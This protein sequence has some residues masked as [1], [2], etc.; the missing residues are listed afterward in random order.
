MSLEVTTF[1]GYFKSEN[2]QYFQIKTNEL[3]DELLSKM[4]E[5]KQAINII[6]CVD[7]SGSMSLDNKLENVKDTLNFL[8]D[9]LRD[10]DQI[11]LVL[12][13]DN[14]E[15]IQTQFMTKANKENLKTI[16]KSIYTRGSTNISSACLKAIEMLSEDSVLNDKIILFLTDGIPNQ[17]IIHSIEMISTLTPK[18]LQQN[19]SL[20][21]FG[22]GSDHDHNLLGKLA[23]T[24]NG[25]YSYIKSNEDVMIS[26][27]NCLGGIFT[28]AIK[29]IEFTFKI[30]D[31]IKFSV[32]APERRQVKINDNETLLIMGNMT[33]GET[34]D[35]LVSFKTDDT[36]YLGECIIKYH[37]E[38]D[39]KDYEENL[40]LIITKDNNI[41]L[42]S[43]DKQF[44]FYDTY[45]R[46]ELIETINI[47]ESI[48]NISSIKE[49][50]VDKLGNDFIEKINNIKEIFADNA[51]YLEILDGYITTIKNI[52]E[53]Q[54]RIDFNCLIRECS[55]GL[56]AQSS[57]G[58]NEYTK[59]YTSKG[60][61]KMITKAKDF[62]K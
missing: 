33:S 1:N 35:F 56:S 46:I 12:F 49:K 43:S 53:M 62:I 55:N 52:M 38:I 31:G 18:I 27:A 44:M 40:E 36:P 42:L 13:D 39:G 20:Y 2:Y 37:N 51:E 17:G 6:V 41:S 54:N 23:S 29:N 5:A 30:R 58:R 45:Y 8:V 7:R 4:E 16:I 25:S 32:L 24:C 50:M 9:Q 10:I 22:Y 19:I 61:E 15:I 34:K 14:I 47:I 21:T 26:F 57:D 59:R 60:K 11:G 28:T 3:S 48:S